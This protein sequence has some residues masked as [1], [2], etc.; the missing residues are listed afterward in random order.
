MNENHTFFHQL[1][2]LSQ[3]AKEEEEEEKRNAVICKRKTLTQ[4]KTKKLMEVNLYYTFIAQNPLV[5]S[6][7]SFTTVVE[8]FH[9]QPNII[10]LLVFPSLHACVCVYD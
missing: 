4:K 1:F 5:I 10:I 3:E 9:Y 2:F 8:M 7:Q 6:N